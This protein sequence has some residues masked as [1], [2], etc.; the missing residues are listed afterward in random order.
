MSTFTLCLPIHDRPTSYEF[1]QAALGLEPVGESVE[2]GIPE[3]L[4]FALAD[5]VILMLI[6]T[7]GFGWVTAG[8]ETAAKN[9]SECLLSLSADTPADVD[10]GF[11]RALDQGAEAV[12]PPTQQPW[13][14]TATFADPDGHLWTLTTARGV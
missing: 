12:T 14:Y 10:A 4:Q 8:R 3:P 11:R 5:R 7:G 13:G 2:D 6:P 9:V 1:Y